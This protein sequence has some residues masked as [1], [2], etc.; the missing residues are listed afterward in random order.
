MNSDDSHHQEPVNLT[1]GLS[2]E[3]DHKY[4][5]RLLWV[6]NI[7]RQP[8]GSG[9]CHRSDR[10]SSQNMG[11]STHHVGLGPLGAAP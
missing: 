6:G 9:P 7:A 8:G 5:L 4:G 2:G 1:A 10:P 3:F 11:G